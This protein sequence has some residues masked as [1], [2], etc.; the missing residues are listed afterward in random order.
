[1]AHPPPRHR[2]LRQ[3]PCANC[4]PL[5]SS[6]HKG[7]PGDQNGVWRLSPK[8]TVPK[9]GV[10]HEGPRGMSCQSP[11]NSTRSGKGGS[12]GPR[13]RRPRPSCKERL[14]PPRP[15]AAGSASRVPIKPRA[16]CGQHASLQLKLI[17][18]F[19]VQPQSPDVIYV[20]RSLPRRPHTKIPAGCCG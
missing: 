10:T 16:A 8:L 19:Q 13:G 9:V 14:P 18:I 3:T 15:L 11:R 17:S 20:H 1:M 7:G 5:P 6:L 4:L 2:K 12:Q